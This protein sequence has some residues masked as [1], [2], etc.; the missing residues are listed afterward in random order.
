MPFTQLG[1][2]QIE[3]ALSANPL[4]TVKSMDAYVH[5]EEPVV[6]S[7]PSVQET[8]LLPTSS[9]WAYFLYC[10]L[11]LKFMAISFLLSWEASEYSSYSHRLDTDCM[12]SNPTF[13]A[14]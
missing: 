13:T 4:T 10:R 2:L 14:S 7:K 9:L 11:H 12:Y 8:S 1:L 5:P 3:D 6:N